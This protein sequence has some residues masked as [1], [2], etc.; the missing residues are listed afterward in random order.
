MSDSW[1]LRRA[2]AL[3]CRDAHMRRARRQA[4]C[5]VLSQSSLWRLPS[6]ISRRRTSD[7]E[8]WARRSGHPVVQRLLKHPA[9]SVTDERLVVPNLPSRIR[10]LTCRVVVASLRQDASVE[11]VVVLCRRDRC[12]G[13]L[14]HSPVV[15]GDALTMAVR[16]RDVVDATGGWLALALV[17]DGFRW[18]RRA[19]LSARR[20]ARGRSVRG[21]GRRVVGDRDRGLAA[22]SGR[23]RP[24]PAW[25]PARG[26]GHQHGCGGC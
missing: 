3:F 25:L 8:P 10:V 21:D 14:V 1:L 18:L 15:S 13:V 5:Q 7:V 23:H 26:A 16:P 19:A 9:R 6:R 20:V 11:R 24:C 12:Q 22:R 4:W 2:G 17:G